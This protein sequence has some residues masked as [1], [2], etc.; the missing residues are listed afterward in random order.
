MR[1]FN[2]PVAKEV[3]DERIK[4]WQRVA[5]DHRVALWLEVAIFEV[6]KQAE[7]AAG[8]A[9]R[10]PALDA[11][12]TDERPL[13]KKQIK[14]VIAMIEARYVDW[15][16]WGMIRAAT[17]VAAEYRDVV[18]DL[19]SILPDLHMGGALSVRDWF[20][21]IRAAKNSTQPARA[22][23]M[24]LRDALRRQPGLGQQT[25]A[26]GTPLSYAF[27]S[28]VPGNDGRRAS[29]TLQAWLAAGIELP[30]RLPAR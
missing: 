24:A 29:A 28:G 12:R 6:R 20:D 15:L 9:R 19:Q 16:G 30:A 4:A 7:N 14:D 11:E 27:G 22:M 8:R 17:Y 21:R 2:L 5:A 13:S 26:P 23:L 18:K 3:T 1:I 25:F 10:P